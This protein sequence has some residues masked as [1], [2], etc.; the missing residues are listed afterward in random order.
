MTQTSN[1]IVVYESMFGS[2]RGIAEAIAAGL[3]TS[4]SCTLV[5]VG[6][7]PTVIDR[8]VDLLVVGAPTHAFGLSTP[9]T[10]REAQTDTVQPV[11]SREMG[12][13]EWLPALVVLSTRTRTAAFD[14]HVKERWI[15]GSASHRI[16]RALRHK[17]VA[18]AASPVS[19]RVAGL[20]GPLL[21]N[22]LERAREWGATL[23]AQ[24]D[25]ARSEPAR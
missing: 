13:R 16:A 25:Q 3:S 4:V 1:A 19:F 5:E 18:A 2:T 14:T 20:T 24:V 21:P 11:I 15:P 6:K 12:V 17:G 9:E 7:A 8:D 23:A 22:E 10:R